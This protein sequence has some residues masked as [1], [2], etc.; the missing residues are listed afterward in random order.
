MTKELRKIMNYDRCK[1]SGIKPVASRWFNWKWDALI[2]LWMIVLLLIIIPCAQA[3]ISVAPPHDAWWATETGKQFMA[4]YEG[5]PAHDWMVQDAVQIPAQKSNAVEHVV[6]YVATHKR[7]LIA[8][9]IVLLAWSADAA[10]SNRC[11]S[12]NRAG[13][14]EQNPLLGKH[15]GPGATWGY[16]MGV[17]SAQIAIGHL[18]WWEGNKVD[19]EAAH[20]IIWLNPITIGIIEYFNVHTNVNIADSG[21]CQVCDGHRAANLA[22]ARTRVSR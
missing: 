2:K 18:V 19:S 6:H 11:Q 17:A 4:G 3:Q 22:L 13:C 7:L 21:A 14:I 5:T 8:D 15:P 12:E 1:R 10:S 9:S 20:V 16:A